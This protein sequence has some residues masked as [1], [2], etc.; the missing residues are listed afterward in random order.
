MVD[1][2]VEVQQSTAGR[3][4]LRPCS[5]RRKMKQRAKST[6]ALIARRHSCNRRQRV[7]RGCQPQ[8][9]GIAA[10]VEDVSF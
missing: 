5:A 2:L 9:G 4:T 1:I 8:I 10:A 7:H 3:A 6:A